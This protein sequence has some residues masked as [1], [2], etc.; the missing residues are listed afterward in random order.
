ME[1]CSNEKLRGLHD[2]EEAVRFQNWPPRVRIWNLHR[3]QETLTGKPFIH[4][5]QHAIFNIFLLPCLALTNCSPI[6]GMAM[7]IIIV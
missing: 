1:K 4:L 6:D 3:A 5:A 7:F 2:T